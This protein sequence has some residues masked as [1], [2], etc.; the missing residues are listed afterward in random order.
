MAQSYQNILVPIDGSIQSE[1]ALETAIDIAKIHQAHLFL[2][3]I[4]DFQFLSNTNFLG[5]ELRESAYINANIILE[6]HEQTVLNS[7]LV[8]VHKI[9]EEGIPKAKISKDLIE[10]YHIEL[11]VMPATGLNTFE[12]LFLGSTTEYV[13][14]HSNC[15]ILVVKSI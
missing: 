13:I 2:A 6:K 5:E 14:R 11:I 3:H 1:L 4:I 12:K 10:K 8:N 9:I 7:K 15:D